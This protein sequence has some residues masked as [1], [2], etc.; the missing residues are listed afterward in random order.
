MDEGNTSIGS[1]WGPVLGVDARTKV[2]RV[3]SARFT[4]EDYFYR[5]HQEG[6][7]L[8]GSFTQND[9]VVSAGLDVALVGR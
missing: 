2:D 8:S 7:L 1:A 6:A 4:V 5:L 9:V 3:I